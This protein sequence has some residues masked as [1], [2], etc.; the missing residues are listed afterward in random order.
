MPITSTDAQ[1]AAALVCSALAG[2]IEEAS[3]AV[4]TAA[5]GS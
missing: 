5:C 3:L 4:N 1:R 2:D